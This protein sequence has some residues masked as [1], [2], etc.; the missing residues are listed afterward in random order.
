MPGRS[1]RPT[2]AARPASSCPSRMAVSTAS[3]VATPSA[4]AEAASLTIAA[5]I[6]ASICAGSSCGGCGPS[7]RRL[8]PDHGAP[9]VA[10]GRVVVAA[11]VRLAPEAPGLD[12]RA[13]ERV[14]PVARIAEELIED[15]RADREVD[16]GADGVDQLERAHRKPDAAHRVVD[17][18]DP[19]PALADDPERLEVV[20]PRDAVDDEA[21][22]VRGDDRRLAEAPGEQ[23]DRIGHFR[24]VA[25]P[26]ITSTS[27][28]SGTGLKKCMPTTRSG[29]RVTDRDRAPPTASSC[30]W[31]GSRRR[32]RS[33][34][35][36]GRRRA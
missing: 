5:R 28:I 24:R 11:A 7:A 23:G 6:R 17:G 10:L 1:A 21:R 25:G 26:A 35:A 27:A 9:R 16:I 12:E 20:R 13:L 33:R 32:P 8:S 31:P 29:R 18:L 36:G 2:P 3:G 14:R 30:S 34:R 4:I 15:R 22:G 19:R